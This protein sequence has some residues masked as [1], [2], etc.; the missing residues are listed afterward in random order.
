LRGSASVPQTAR[1]HALA[2][3][4]S[5]LSWAAHALFR[6]FEQALGKDALDSPPDPDREQRT[7]DDLSSQI[8]ELKAQ[9]ERLQAENREL[10]VRSCQLLRRNSELEALQSLDSHN[11]SRPPSTDPGWR[12]RTKSLRVASGKLPGGQA[13]HRG[14]R[15]P[16]TA[17]LDRIV[18]HRPGHCRSCHA[19]LTE[20]QIIRHLKQQVIEVRPAR[21]RVTEH[22]LYVVRCPACGK[23]TKGEFAQA[24]RSG[25][26]YGPGVK[27]RVLY[28]QQYQLLPIAK[29]R[30]AMRDLFGCHLS[31]G[32]V[33]NIIK[34]CATGLVQTEL[35]IKQQL[36]RSTVI[37]AD[38][39]GLRV[40]GR[41]H[42]IHVAST[43]RLTHDGG[44]SRRGKAAMDEIGILPHYRGN[45]MHDGWWSYDGYTK[46]RHSLC[47]VHLL[48][49]LTFFAELSAEQKSWA[50]PLKALLLEI[51][52]RV[53]RGR[54]GESQW[55]ESEEQ[56]AFINR[57]DELLEQG[58]KV[59][60]P[61]ASQA[62]PAEQEETQIGSCDKQARNLL[63]RMQRKKEQVLRFMTDLAVPY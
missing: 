39:T 5:L 48:R 42:Y 49:E 56:E 46:C 59:N 51:K 44:D 43:H 18:E 8:T 9:L 10:R 12:K 36:R 62:G 11:S 13:G 52:A 16:L 1:G 34:Q 32:T 47:G 50:M 37:H 17:H 27:A 41:G 31:G 60:K 20:A 33:V 58:L 38:E 63:L 19:A 35:K 45:L 14:E 24:V 30:E 21:L 29:T 53:E 22:R 40:A 25:V 15:P 7:I 61:G 2:D 4:P 3:L 23:K 57:Y 55:L 28:L 6:L 54:E 26:Q